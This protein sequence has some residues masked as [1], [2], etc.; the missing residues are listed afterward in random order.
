MFTTVNSAITT[1]TWFPVTF[2]LQ[3]HYFTNYTS[4]DKIK[5]FITHNSLDTFV[6]ISDIFKEDVLRC[7]PFSTGELSHF[8]LGVN[9]VLTG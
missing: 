1:N 9:R 3:I 6:D 8:Y 5:H 7:L 4:K 2:E